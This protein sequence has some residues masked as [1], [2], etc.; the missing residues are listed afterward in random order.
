MLKKFVLFGLLFSC[1]HTHVH[2]QDREDEKNALPEIGVVASNAISIEKEKQLGDIFMRQLRGQSPLISDPLLQEYIQDLGNRLVT[3]ADNVKF[4]FTFF[5]LNNQSINAFAFFGGHIGIHTGLIYH[6]SDESELAS[7]IAHEIAHVTQ[8]HIARS[9]QAQQKFSPVAMLSMLGGILLAVAD[10]EAGFATISATSAAARQSSINYTRSNEKE[11]DRI[12]MRILAEAGYDPNA[13]VRFFETLAAK[14]RHASNSTPFLFTHPLPDSRIADA[15]SRAAQF[16]QTNAAKSLDFELAK[17][18]IQARYYADAKYNIRYFQNQLDENPHP[19]AA[20][21]YG[22]ALSLFENE[23]FDKADK[24][25]GTLIQQDPENLF[26]IDTATDIA[27]AKENAPSAIQMLNKHLSKKPLNQVITLNL[28]NVYIEDKQFEKAV[29]LLKDFMLVNPEH[30]L[31]QQLIAVA[32]ERSG[33]NMRMRQARAEIGALSGRYE[34]AIDELQH[35]Y[36]LARST[37]SHLEKQRI[38]AR[39]D[40]FR[41]A[42]QQLKSL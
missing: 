1:A 6:A 41:A 27:L 14:Y 7:V 22:L 20:H 35:A 25:I 21:K 23:Q 5:L 24:I 38:Q 39:I 42:Q 19:S 33:Q 16:K 4:P 12:G 9:I 17:A 2:G 37:G 30:F 10:P 8:R 31:A 26:Y 40:Q 36:N 32:Y 28:A 34:P 29:E 13:S 15:R 18:R 11:A 3:Q